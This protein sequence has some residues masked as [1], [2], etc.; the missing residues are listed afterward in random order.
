MSTVK[1]P[2]VLQC[3]PRSLR[4][5]ER[6]LNRLRE[7]PRDAARHQEESVIIAGAWRIDSFGN[8]WR[9]EM[10]DG[11]LAR[12]R[13]PEIPLF[14]IETRLIKFLA[15]RGVR[16]ESDCQYSLGGRDIPP[17]YARCE[18]CGEGWTL[19]NV[20]DV[21]RVT[22][23]LMEPAPLKRFAGRRFLEAIREIRRIF[24]PV[25][26]F[27]PMTIKRPEGTIQFGSKIPEDLVI[28][29]GDIAEG[30]VH[31]FHHRACHH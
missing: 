13:F 15:D 9:V 4:G 3:A 24:A 26:R 21:V 18:V 2:L 17:S 30:F 6:S 29:V 28:D 5:L 8:E 19:E 12:D 1:K 10:I 22:R 14:L 25:G 16:I 11:T 31:R 27:L 7:R 20:H 23:N